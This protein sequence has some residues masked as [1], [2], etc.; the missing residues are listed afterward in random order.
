MRIMALDLGGYQT[1][2]C[3]YDTDSGSQQFLK[4]RSMPQELHD[5]LVEHRPVCL[6][7]E[8]GPQAG[9]V[10][11]IAAGLSV[12]VQVANPNHEGWRWRRVKRK[13]DRAD[14]LKLAQLS[15]MNQLPLTYLPAR[16][17]RQ[18]RSLIRHRHKLMNHRVAVKNLIRSVLLRE[19]VAWPEGKRGW[20]QESVAAL[21]ELAR[22]IDVVE[23]DELWRAQLWLA[24]E[25]LAGVER[26]ISAVDR[27]LDEIGRV[28]ERVKRLQ[29]IPGV[30]PRLAE[31]V[32]AMID[33]PELFRRANQVAA[34]AG[35]TPKQLESGTM[36]ISGR[37]TKQ[38]DPL[39]RTL[40]V[41]ASWLGL[42]HNPWVRDIYHR[43]RK[44]SAARNKLAIIAVARRL[45]IRCWAMLRDQSDWRP[46][47]PVAVPAG[48]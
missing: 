36:Q 42:L 37:I 26:L 32:V 2:V 6:V 46:A 48:S 23:L 31:V 21:K 17:V 12:E 40:L 38:G 4:V 39:L 28:D 44:G 9:W 10:H 34:Y 13:T 16:P 22:P 5:L 8:I 33:K 24:L 30:G 11:D 27:R 47:E 43:T 15:V 14:A 19:A 25:D 3:E 20:T 7:F 18:W 45:L 29:T 41:E 1:T 35:L